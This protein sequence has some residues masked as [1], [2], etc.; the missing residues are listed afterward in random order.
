M[1]KKVFRLFLKLGYIFLIHVK[2]PLTQK[3][4]HPCYK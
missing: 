4:E 3:D 1:F 2:K